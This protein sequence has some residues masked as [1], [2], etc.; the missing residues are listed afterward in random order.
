MAKTAAISVRVPDDVKAAVEKAAEADSRSVASLV[1]KILV[2]YL[3]KNGYLKGPKP[4][5]TV[6]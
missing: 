2:D 6:L 1:E 4:R 3:K 5:A